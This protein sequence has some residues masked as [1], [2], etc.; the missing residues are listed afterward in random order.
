MAVFQLQTSELPYLYFNFVC[1]LLHCDICMLVWICA[2]VHMHVEARSTSC[3]F[4]SC[5]SSYSVS[6]SL[7]WDG[8]SLCSTDWPG[9]CYVDHTGFGLRNLP[10]SASQ[11][12]DLKAAIMPGLHLTFLRQVLSLGL[13]LTDWGS[14]AGSKHQ[15]F[16][17]F[18]PL[19]FLTWWGAKFSTCAWRASTLWT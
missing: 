16:T 17:C 15:M 18:H 13:E 1:I 8:V 3:V 9:I 5:A 2:C 12:L 19:G 11:L 4:L 7:C 10:A 6:E 14:L